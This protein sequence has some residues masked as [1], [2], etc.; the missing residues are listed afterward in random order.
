MRTAT[1]PVSRWPPEQPYWADG[2]PARIHENQPRAETART[3]PPAVAPAR[4]HRRALPRPVRLYH[5]QA[6]RRQRTA[7]VPAP[8]RRLRQH[9]GVRDLPR[10]PRRLPGQLPAQ[11]TAIRNP[12]RSPRLRLRPLPRRPHRMDHTTR[13]RY[14]HGFTGRSTSHLRRVPGDPFLPSTCSPGPAGLRGA[15]A[16]PAQRARRPRSFSILRRSRLVGRPAPRSRAATGTASWRGGGG[17][18]LSM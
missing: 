2:Q 4:R 14:T 5:R 1:A 6:A 18:L 10:Q 16:K 7:A 15:P 11:R 9:L 12:R 17:G 8:L 3:R 13:H